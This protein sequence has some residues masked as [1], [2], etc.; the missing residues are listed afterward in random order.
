MADKLFHIYGQ[1]PGEC[2]EFIGAS[3]CSMVAIHRANA[4]LD[5]GSELACVI[6][7]TGRHMAD[8]SI[9][10]VCYVV[11]AE[12]NVRPRAPKGE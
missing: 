4:L 6:E 9:D 11:R 8:I 1:K 7:G 3:P 10:S 2:L 12:L 5:T